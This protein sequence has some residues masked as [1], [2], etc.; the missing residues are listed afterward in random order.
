MMDG[1]T[2]FQLSLKEI[3]H[4]RERVREGGGAIHREKE[5]T[6]DRDGEG[7]R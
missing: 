7:H 3:T 2:S 5:T 4:E 1:S 6:I